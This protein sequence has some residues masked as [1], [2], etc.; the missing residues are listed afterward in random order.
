MTL[1]HT[2]PLYHS[3]ACFNQG[4]I[5]KNWSGFQLN[6][7]IKYNNMYLFIYWFVWNVMFYYSQNQV[8]CILSSI[9]SNTFTNIF[10]SSSKV[11]VCPWQPQLKDPKYR[12][13]QT[14][15]DYVTKHTL[16]V[17]DFLKLQ[18]SIWVFH[19]LGSLTALVLKQHFL[20]QCTHKDVRPFWKSGRDFLQNVISSSGV[21]WH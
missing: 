15:A 11:A 8:Y 10:V 13:K 18:A 19:L 20:H 16:Y 1:L 3:F 6:W 4:T 9:L 21:E 17:H 7:N 14:I 12:K 5:Q 2:K